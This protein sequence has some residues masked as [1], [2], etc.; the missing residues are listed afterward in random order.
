[1]AIHATV[2]DSR[3]VYFGKWIT[4]NRSLTIARRGLARGTV[5]L[6]TSGSSMLFLEH[7]VLLVM[8]SCAF[9]EWH[10]S[11]TKSMSLQPRPLLTLF[12]PIEM[13]DC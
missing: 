2:E 13:T 8:D 5:L 10:I 6:K 4:L 11:I 1:V 3:I 7:I 9:L 12:P